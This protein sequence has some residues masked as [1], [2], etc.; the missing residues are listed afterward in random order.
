M[1][2]FVNKYKQ[3][4]GGA[5]PKQI[6]RDGKKAVTKALHE[7]FKMAQGGQV[8]GINHHGEQ[9]LVLKQSLFNEIIQSGGK[10][11]LSEEQKE[12]YRNH[13]I[14]LHMMQSLNIEDADE[15]MLFDEIDQFTFDFA[16][17]MNDPK[18]AKKRRE[19]L[20]EF[21]EVINGNEL[22]KNL[23]INLT[24]QL[25]PETIKEEVENNGKLT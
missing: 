7:A 8:A 1:N 18:K 4:M 5:K 11:L 19:V 3:K 21:N 15:S 20:E 16:E 23:K 17:N 14:L 22:L 13:Q 24:K 25:F 10:M 12:F 2:D 6:K 9:F